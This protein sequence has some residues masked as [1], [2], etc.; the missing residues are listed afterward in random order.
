MALRLFHVYMA[1][2]PQV[3]LQDD[4]FM[5]PY[6]HL[7][8]LVLVALKLCCQLDAPGQ[9]LQEPPDWHAW[10]SAVVQH[11]QG[12]HT[13]PTTALEVWTQPSTLNGAHDCR[14]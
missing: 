3:W 9:H 8:A 4:V 1:G 5:H 11:S 2:C 13:F 6:A 7:M 14:L 12:P 10:A